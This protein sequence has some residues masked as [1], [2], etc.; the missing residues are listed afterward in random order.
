MLPGGAGREGRACLKTCCPAG[1]GEVWYAASLELVRIV[2]G[3]LRRMLSWPSEGIDDNFVQWVSLH[4]Y[5]L[6]AAVST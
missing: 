3:R 5:D 6:I 2:L 1:V 4:A